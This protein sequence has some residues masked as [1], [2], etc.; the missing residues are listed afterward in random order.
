MGEVTTYSVYFKQMGK[1]NTDRTFELAHARAKALQIDMV[2]VASTSG[3]TGVKA[4]ELMKGLNIVVV[5]HSFGFKEANTQE[6][7]YVNLSKIESSGGKVLTCAHAFGGINRGIRKKWG[8]YQVDEVIAQTLRTFSEGMKVAVEIAVM[9]A[10]AGLVRTDKPV[11]SIGGT[12]KGADTAV[13]LIPANAQNF[14]DLKILEVVC[15]P[16]IEHP[17]R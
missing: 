16:A 8:T 1:E 4:V 2:L 7:S 6:L 17:C 14:F 9:A 5:S 12:G 10:D 15:M 11:M 3:D 13:I